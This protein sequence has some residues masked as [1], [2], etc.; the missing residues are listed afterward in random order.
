MDISFIILLGVLFMP[1]ITP[2]YAF[3]SNLTRPFACIALLPTILVW[4][5]IVIKLHEWIVS[6][7]ITLYIY[8]AVCGLILFLYR[9]EIRV[10]TEKEE[11]ENKERKETEKIERL[12]QQLRDVGIDPD[13][14]TTLDVCLYSYNNKVLSCNYI[15]NDVN[16][17]AIEI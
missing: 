11:T 17:I 1:I 4:I 12:K 8:G 14:P 6:T 15:D 16:D 5:F 7:L 2:Y 9:D 13:K 3:K 10:E